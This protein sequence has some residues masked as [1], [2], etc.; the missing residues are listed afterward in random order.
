MQ[1]GYVTLVLAVASSGCGFSPHATAVDAAL[2]IDTAAD[3]LEPVTWTVDGTSGKRVPS[4]LKE[5]QDLIATRDLD[6]SPPE[7][8][9]LAQ[10][11]GG[12]L[13]DAIGGIV[14]G[15]QGNVTYAKHLRGW[16]P[17]GVGPVT[18][19]AQNGVFTTSPGHL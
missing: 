14:V 17:V 18:T 5:W 13:L 11:T 12:V 19:G 16:A 2:P 10:E 6:A 9:W 8:L 1:G 3:T 15:G 4:S 7:H